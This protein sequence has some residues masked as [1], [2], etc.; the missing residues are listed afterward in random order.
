[1][2][3]ATR[4]FLTRPDLLSVME[5]QGDGKIPAAARMRVARLMVRLLV[6]TTSE[7][8]ARPASDMVARRVMANLSRL[9]AWRVMDRACTHPIYLSS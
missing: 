2:I 6:R 7:G 1:M 4:L 8:A 5:M 3:E 9:V